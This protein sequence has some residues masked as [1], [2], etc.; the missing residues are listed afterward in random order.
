MHLPSSRIYREIRSEE[1]G[2]WFVPANGGKETAV[3]IK[4]PTSTLK[5]LLAGAPLSFVFAVQDKYLC[6]GVRVY[7][8]PEAPLLLCSVQR[9][10]EEHSAL[11]QIA[12]ACNSPIFLF[13]EVDTCVAWSDSNITSEDS[14]VLCD[15]L[16]A[17]QEFYAGDF[18]TEA[19]RFLD[20]F[21]ALTDQQKRITGTARFRA[22]ET[23]VAHGPW[24]SNTVWFAGIQD[25]QRI[26]LGDI[27]E[28]GVLESAVWASLESAFPYSLHRSPQVTV[29]KKQREL[30]DV[31]A[32]YEYGSFFIEAKDL[33]IL[34]AGIYRTRERRLSGIQK[35][36]KK[37]I[38]QLT[39]ASKAA[40]RGEKV[41]DRHGHPI[42]LVLDQP[43]HC[44]VLLSDL[45][46]EGDW[47]LIEE[48][49]RTAMDETR[50]FFHLLDLREFVTLL[51]CSRGDARLLDYNLMKRCERFVATGS[52]HI[53]SRPAPPKIDAS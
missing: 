2:A 30:V 44:I 18:T 10:E 16:A 4:A 34:A 47:R 40:K 39:G 43:I 7:D 22:Q 9:H 27:D 21:C 3:L 50:D 12:S 32:F 25:S 20:E 26:I 23:T 28:G 11:R 42:S 52:V 5:A 29:G 41:T 14:A 51:K 45:M 38:E 24:T 8:V 33:S 17:D 46:H 49:L 31:A 53:R 13:N 6:S 15:F 35:Q 48:S 19:S 37:A 1:G 36:T